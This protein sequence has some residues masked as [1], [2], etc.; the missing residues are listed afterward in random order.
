MQQKMRDEQFY[1]I[2]PDNDVS[3]ETDKKRMLWTVGDAVKGRQPLSRWRDEY[4]DE[5][6][7]ERLSG[8]EELC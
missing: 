7:W 1:I 8:R 5:V 2:C 6:S 4:K 3:E